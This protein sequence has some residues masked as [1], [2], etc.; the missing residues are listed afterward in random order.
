MEQVLT[1]LASY[2]LPGV[3]LPGL[4]LLAY[5]LTDRGCELKFGYGRN[6][7]DQWNGNAVDRIRL[8][9]RLDYQEWSCWPGRPDIA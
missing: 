6:G 5:R 3:P 2:G 8:D 7:G 1:V 4:L 9:R